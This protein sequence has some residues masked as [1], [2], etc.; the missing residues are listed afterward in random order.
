MQFKAGDTLESNTHNEVSAKMRGQLHKTCSVD[1][2]RIAAVVK[3]IRLV[4]LFWLAILLLRKVHHGQGQ[5]NKSFRNYSNNEEGKA[6]WLLFLAGIKIMYCDDV[7]YDI[8]HSI[9]FNRFVSR[10]WCVDGELRASRR[11]AIKRS[12]NRYQLSTEIN[13]YQLSTGQISTI[14]PSSATR[15][16]AST[17]NSSTKPTLSIDVVS[18]VGPQIFSFLPLGSILNGFSSP[19]LVCKSFYDNIHLALAEFETLDFSQCAH[20]RKITDSHLISLIKNI[21]KISER[22]RPD[23]QGSEISRLIRSLTD[24][25]STCSRLRVKYLGLSRCRY[26]EGE[27]VLYCLSEMRGIERIS[28]SMCESFDPEGVGFGLPNILSPKYVEYID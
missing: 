10:T 20:L 5:K 28:L 21:V 3:R 24:S 26:I 8:Y 9:T 12:I 23:D 1:F 2:M 13:R 14:S 7:N 22:T 11:Q 17:M 27:G 25:D 15:Q 6:F 18:A 16:C 4:I 19:L